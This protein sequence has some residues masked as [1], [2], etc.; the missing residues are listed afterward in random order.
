MTATRAILSV[1]P[2]CRRPRWKRWWMP[3]GRITDSAAMYSA[4]RTAVRL[5]RINCWFRLWPRSREHGAS[6][7][8]QSRPWVPLTQCGQIRPPAG[9]RS[10]SPSHRRVIRP[11][12]RAACDWGSGWPPTKRSETSG[13]WP[14]SD[15]WVMGRAQPRLKL[16]AV[17]PIELLLL[18]P[19]IGTTDDGGQGQAEH[20]CERMSAGVGTEGSGHLFQTRLQGRGRARDHDRNPIGS[21]GSLVPGQA[22][23]NAILQLP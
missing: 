12:G 18:H 21:T 17:V 22:A 10:R 9:P 13:G 14:S 11:S 7:T 19:G 4:W 2:R 6:P 16:G 15:L 5:P 20:G 8:V 23:C 3:S 1:L